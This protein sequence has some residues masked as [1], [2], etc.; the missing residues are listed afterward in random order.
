MVKVKLHEILG[1]NNR[2]P[3]KMIYDGMGA[4]KMAVC[5]HNMGTTARVYVYAKMFWKELELG[6]KSVLTV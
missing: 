4:G 3:E 6:R 1:E 2:V 5:Q